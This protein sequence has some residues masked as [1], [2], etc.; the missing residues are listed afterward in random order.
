MKKFNAMVTLPILAEPSVV[1][2]P[3]EEGT[4]R[5]QLLLLEPMMIRLRDAHDYP[6]Y[7][8]KAPKGIFSFDLDLLPGGSF[9]LETHLLTAVC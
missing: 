5:L 3:T 2:L 6:V 7:S 4:N 1:L 8:S 9:T